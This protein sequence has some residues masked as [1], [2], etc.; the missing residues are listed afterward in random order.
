MK[1]STSIGGATLVLGVLLVACGA[2]T[3]DFKV[4]AERF[5]EGDRM[6]TESGNTFTDAVCQEPTSTDVG[7]TF[8]CVATDGE[9]TEWSFDVA[10]V[11][12]SNFQITGSHNA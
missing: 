10:I 9:G 4:S 7:T 5:I 1:R 3:A 8:R 11:D 12:E 2:D 6:T